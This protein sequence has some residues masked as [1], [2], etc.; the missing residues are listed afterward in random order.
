MPGGITKDLTMFSLI[1]AATG[2]APRWLGVCGALAAF[3]VQARTAAEPPVPAQLPAKLPLVIVDNPLPFRQFDKVEIT[4]SS[5]VRKAQTQSLP[6]QTL[7]RAEIV[8]SGRQSTS[9]LLQALP[10]MANFFS[11]GMLGAVKSGFNGGAIHGLQTGTLVLVNGRRL[12]GNGSQTSSGT[13]NGGTDLNWLP[14][15]A[16]ERIEILTDGASSIYGTDAQTG[17]INIITR[18]SLPAHEITFEH[19]SP[20]RQKGLG[21]RL[22]L[23]FGGGRIERQGYSWLIAADVQHQ[24]E[25]LGRDRPYASAGRYRLRHDGQDYWAYGPGTTAAQTSPTLASSVSPPYAQLWN[26]DAR[27]GQC[28][29]DKVPAWGQNACLDNSYRDKGL[30]PETRSVRVHAQARLQLTPDIVGHAELSWQHHDQRRSLRS[31]GQYAARI[32]TRPDAPGHDLALANGLDPAQ[33][34]WLLWSGSAL[35]PAPVWYGIRTQRAVAGLKGQWQGWDFNTGAYHSQSRNT[36]D[37]VTLASYP[38]LGVDASGVLVNP[39]LL[40]AP[41]ASPVLMQQLGSMLQKRPSEDGTQSLSGLDLKASRSVGE[42]DGRDIYLALGTDW[43]Q[44]QARFNNL[45]PNSVLLPSYRGERGVW[46]QF[47]ELQWPLMEHLEVIGALRNDRYSD[48]G[49]TTH[50]KLSAKWSPS[51]RWLVR[52]AWGSSFRAPAIG[53][54]QDTARSL[55]ARVFVSC[56]SALQAI[57]QQLGGSC[58][59]DNR[60]ALYSQ[61]S[62]QLRPELSTQS[63]LGLR[64]SPDRNHTLALDY[65]RI[66]VRD[67]INSLNASILLA[68]PQKYI[69]NFSLNARQELELFSPMVNIGKTH[70]A[71]IDFSWAL[72]RPTGWGQLHLALTGTWM[73]SAHHQITDSDPQVSEL[74]TYSAA[75]GFVLPRLKTRWQ[76]GL[77]RQDWQA[78]VTVQHVGAHDGGPVNAIHAETGQSVRL[79]GHRVPSWA[80]VDLLVLYPWDRKT[81]LQLG[82]DNVLNRKAPLDLGFASSFNFGTNPTLANSWGRTVQL[83]VTHRF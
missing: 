42:I 20:D 63:N 69:G 37:V 44:E 6:V 79:P 77:Q 3:T 33:G 18:A 34:A 78:W 19:R 67:K 26:A 23:A 54:M 31:W 12:A 71:G 2:A 41:Q 52:G 11:P 1:L 28:P 17:V 5:I 81:T 7:T 68:D 48:F 64:F 27:Q 60:Y 73:L 25:L 51:A 36:Y 40:A 62:S 24:Q 66:D 74:G 72:R 75:T 65:W 46:A 9:E 49:N 43:R 29:A 16:I 58:P 8:R 83:S 39:A 22:D 45:V 61:G 14:L 15:S 56:S 4:G 50:A 47:A 53:Q 13:D 38:N 76:L 82:I 21:Q 80:S 55:S 59:A 32:G 10:V 30:Y 57:A 35:G 70:N